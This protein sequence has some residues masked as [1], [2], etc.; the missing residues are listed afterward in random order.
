MDS[1]P[2][3]KH[4][5][6]NEFPIFKT[7]SPFCL[8]QEGGPVSFTIRPPPAPHSVSPWAVFGTLKSARL[9]AGGLQTCAQAVRAAVSQR[10]TLTAGPAAQAALGVALGWLVEGGF[11]FDGVSVWRSFVSL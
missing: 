3:A 8:A 10:A 7:L 9:Q 4:A 6:A 5:D 2:A 11:F 1:L